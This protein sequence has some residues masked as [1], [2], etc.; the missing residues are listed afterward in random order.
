MRLGKALA[1]VL[2]G[3]FALG[4]VISIGDSPKNIGVFGTS[5]SA[6]VE[7]FF[8]LLIAGFVYVSMLKIFG[9]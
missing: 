5:T 2:F 6:T 3:M 1:A 9:D 4:Q 7:I 8:F